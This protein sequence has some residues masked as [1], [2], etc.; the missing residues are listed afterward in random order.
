FDERDTLRYV[1]EH[2]RQIP[3]KGIGY[4]LL[5]Y[6]GIDDEIADKLR[7]CPQAEI[8]FNYFGQFD[9]VLSDSSPLTPAN[10]STGPVRSPDTIRPHLIEITGSIS[11]GKLHLNWI[12]SRNVHESRTIEELSDSFLRDLRSL[13]LH[14]STAVGVGYT[15]SDFPECGLS[16]QS[17][18]E[19]VA[20]LDS[21][22]GDDCGIQDIYPL[23]PL[24]QGILFHSLYAPEEQIYFRQLRCIIEGDVK[25]GALRQ[26]WTELIRRHS[27]LRTGF[28]W[29]RI[30]Q[31]LQI[32]LL[33]ADLDWEEQDWQ[34]LNAGE[35]QSQ[36]EAF[37]ERDRDRG[38]DLSAPPLMRVALMRLDET[39]YQLIWTVDHI[40]VDGWSTSLIF[41]EV[42]T[43]YDSF[44][45]GAQPDLMRVP[46][47]R[48]Y[49]SWLQRQD[50]EQ[51]EA[52]WRQ[53]LKGFLAPTPLSI[54][55]P[56]RTTPENQPVYAEPRLL[57]SEAETERVKEGAREARV[58]V[59]TIV[60]GAW[61]V[62]LARYSQEEEVVYG[63]TVAGRPAELEGVERMVGLFINTLAVRAKV[64]WEK[65]VGEWLR[66]QQQQQ[67]EMR[68]YEY[69]PLMKVQGWSEVG[70][71][72]ALFDTLLVY[73]NYPVE[74]T[75]REAAATGVSG[76]RVKE[77]KISE[78]T[79]YGVTVIVGPGRRMS[80]RVGYY[81]SRY[82][83]EA[84]KRL[85]MQLKV[86]LLELAQSRTSKLK[87]VSM[88]SEAER[89]QIVY[90]WNQTQREYE[91]D[92][93]LVEKFEEVSR[94][95]PERIAVASGGEEISYQELNQRANQLGRYLRKRGV[96]AEWAVG[97][98]MER[99]LEMVVGL[100]GILKAGGAYV[101][102]DPEYPQ[103]RVQYMVADAGAGLVITDRKSRELL[104]ELAAETVEIEEKREEIGRE[105]VED[106]GREAGG[107]NLAYIIYTSGSTGQ[108][109]GVAIEHG[110]AVTF[111]NWC[112]EQFTSEEM[113]GVLASTSICFDLSVFELFA[114]LS[115]GG[116][117]ILA[118]NALQ[119]PELPNR[120]EITLI[121]TVPSAA[122]ALVSMNAIPASVQVINLAGEPFTLDLA[123]KLY[124]VESVKSVFN[125]YGLS[126][127]TTYST[128]AFVDRESQR[129]P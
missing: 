45:R 76:M 25:T 29:S 40:I 102:L 117:V 42:L 99:G 115:M 77:V 73:E 78:T 101:P 43:L 114:T 85:I 5:R 96:R 7:N 4:G 26:A 111:I 44:Y 14:C 11:G 12:Y 109:K 120:N 106:L 46:P 128:V 84:M 88:L 8:S 33:Q 19:L 20:E 121:N 124:A 2:L 32:V 50:I 64:K 35:Q 110:S 104:G 59:N 22:N 23:S 58:T 1:K 16:Q 15:P 86:V 83:S 90:E 126:E 71:G 97:I 37:L 91:T 38:F 125:L 28:I 55:R 36:L 69:S 108:P 63:V 21:A 47:Y 95:W 122:A 60:A 113:A 74:E 24:Q 87:Q 30:D 9:Q 119:L 27:I 61:A 75:V 92:Q 94:R 72:E 98:M 41:K 3:D 6:L 112:M 18:D 56:A 80:L 51:A 10:E 81:E 17:L 67:A 107:R 62:L 129:A 82:E 48:E 13:I 65:E 105:R 116:K 68:E 66:E 79:N 100:L 53:A 103:Q 54:P 118:K 127:D 34:R 89:R 49:I 57:L 31:P 123:R 70:S 39:H 93:S 52:Y